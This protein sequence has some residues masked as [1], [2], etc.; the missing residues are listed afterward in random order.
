MTEAKFARRAEIGRER[1]ERTRHKLITA[2]AR[3]IAAFG[4]KLPTIDDFISAAGLA[5]GTFYNYFETREQLVE[6][7]WAHLGKDP[8]LEIERICSP[9]KDPAE[10]ITTMTRLV[11]ARAR[12]DEIWGWLIYSLSSD[13]QEVNADLLTY[14]MADLREGEAQGRLL[15][16]DIEVARDL[17]VSVIRKALRTQL[18]A[19]RGNAYDQT[20]CRMVLLALG[21]TAAEAARLVARPLP[22]LPAH[23][24]PASRN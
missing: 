9:I 10:R 6:A 13:E 20:I 2:A 14:P 7:V 3:V 8:F 22:T 24:P 11:L 4:S 5:R 12:Q 1:R 23:V 18:V 15:F 16:D 19:P 21:V 17:V